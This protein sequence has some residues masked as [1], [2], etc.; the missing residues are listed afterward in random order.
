MK[1]L[2]PIVF[3]LL[4]STAAATPTADNLGFTPVHMCTNSTVVVPLNTTNVANGP[5]L[6]F[7]CN[8]HF[9][10]SI[11]Q[12]EAV[13]PSNLTHDWSILY[14]N[15]PYGIRIAGVYDGDLNHSL[16]NGS[17]GPIALLHFKPVAPGQTYLNLSDIQLSGPN[18]QLGTAPAQNSTL[19]VW[20]RGDLNDDG[21][22]ADIGD[23]RLMWEAFLGLRPTD[24]RYDINVDGKEAG[25]GDVALI[26]QMY[27]GAI[28][29]LD[30]FLGGE[31]R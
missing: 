3:V 23:V 27:L 24:C 20:Q 10:S 30:I 28:G 6:S 12:V 15:K 14:A 11:A 25:I 17:T 19:T 8:V 2:L 21:E 16:H 31:T 26:W 22:V 18:Y 29:S 5:I 9:N 1:K 4:A 13:L 7:I